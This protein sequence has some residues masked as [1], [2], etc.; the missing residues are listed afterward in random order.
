MIYIILS[1]YGVIILTLIVLAFFIAYHLLK[2]SLNA[3]LNKVMLPVFIVISILLILSNMFLFFSIDW[4][5][6]I[7]KII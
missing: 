7:S 2:Y 6:L 4:V 5:N 1:L 3:N